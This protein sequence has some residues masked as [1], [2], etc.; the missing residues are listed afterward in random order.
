MCQAPACSPSPAPRISLSPGTPFISRP[1][2]TAGRPLRLIP[3][4]IDRLALRCAHC[5]LSLTLATASWT[6]PQATHFQACRCTCMCPCLVCRPELQACIL[7]LRAR[8]ASPFMLICCRQ[9]LPC[10]FSSNARPRPPPPNF[11]PCP[12][13]SSLPALPLQRRLA[14]TNTSTCSFAIRDHLN[15]AL[16]SKLHARQP[17][18]SPGPAH[19]CMPPLGHSMHG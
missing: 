12:A 6:Y 13:A 8:A 7:N 15:A 17:H 16:G 1:P 4:A 19:P 11:L 9:Q 10:F 5:Q 3:P 18:H 2:A 14:A